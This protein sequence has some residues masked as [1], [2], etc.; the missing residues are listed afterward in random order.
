MVLSD[1]SA[2]LF[3]KS[4]LGCGN[5]T[6]EVPSHFAHSLT[7]PPKLTA[8]PSYQATSNTIAEGGLFPEL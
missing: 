5:H 6:R 2:T 8:Q 4:Y 1:Q 3:L 7:P